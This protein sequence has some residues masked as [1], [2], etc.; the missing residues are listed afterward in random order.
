MRTRGIDV[1]S[2]RVLAAVTAAL[3]TL[4]LGGR[5]L[6]PMAPATG[7]AGD[8]HACCRA[9]LQP[10]P[11]SCCVDAPSADA[12][13]RETVVAAA[14]APAAVAFAAVTAMRACSVT[15]PAICASPPGPSPPHLSS[16]LRI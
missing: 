7:E 5:G 14:V 8:P 12:P 3:F 11:P 16:V 2:R 1:S 6:C 13:A 10:A 15:A 9:G 4:V